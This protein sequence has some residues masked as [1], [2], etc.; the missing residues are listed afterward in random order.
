M[1]ISPVRS[2][3]ALGGII[4]L[5]HLV[6]SVLVAVGVAQAVLDFILWAHFLKVP[7]T[8]APFSALTAVVLVAVTFVVG[9]LLGSVFAALWN[10]LHQERGEVRRP[11]SA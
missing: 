7:V 11:A 1:A 8:L 9:F 5:W 6:W 2:G 3:I 10:W 4:A